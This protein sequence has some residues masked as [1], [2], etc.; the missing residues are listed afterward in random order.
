MAVHVVIFHD[1]NQARAACDLAMKG[2]IQIE[3]RSPPGGAEGMGPSVFNEIAKDLQRTHDGIISAIILD[4][5]SNTGSAL[6]AFRQGCKDICIDVS[7]E[8]RAKL[9]SIS[10]FMEVCIHDETTTG[11]NLGAIEKFDT[12]NPECF[13]H[14]LQ[15]YLSEDPACG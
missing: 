11:L 10:T 9:E 8:V 2:G 15:A 13:D 4:C 5:G 7:D 14:A 12:D 3:L 1:L 6:A